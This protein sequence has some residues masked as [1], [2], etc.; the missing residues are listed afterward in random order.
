MTRPH[1]FTGLSIGVGFQIATVRPLGR[2]DVTAFIRNWYRIAYGEH[3]LID[4]A[5]QLVDAI[6]D[7]ERIEALATN[8][9]LCTI[10]AVVFRNNRV[11]PDRRVELGDIIL[12]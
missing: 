3:A 9:L 6:R 11:L 12:D 2:D 10:I 7:N 5:G 4:E 8:P 1:G